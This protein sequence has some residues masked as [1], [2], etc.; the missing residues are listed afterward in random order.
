MS[1]IIKANDTRHT[2]RGMYSL[3]LR[4]IA[5]EA[6][7]IVAAAR[8]EAERIVEDARAR[9]E[10]EGRSTKEAARREGHGQGMTEGRASGRA[11]ALAEAREEFGRKQESLVTALS[12]LVGD[13][14]KRREYLYAACRRDVVVL[15]VAIASRICERFAGMADEASDAAVRACEEALS[16]V[17][18]ATDVVI[19]VHPED[20][21]ALAQMADQL[22]SS[23]KSSRHVRIVDDPAIGRGGVEVGAADSTI[24]ATIRS[25]VEHIA[26]ELVTDWRRRMKELSLAG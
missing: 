21:A 15:A 19:R 20:S 3:D 1:G 23:V 26:D 6:E 5:R 11:A 12:K 4:D 14:D 24:D 8:A 7:S 25:R 9:A 10:V 16:M 17:R 13:F 22:A 2:S 18:G